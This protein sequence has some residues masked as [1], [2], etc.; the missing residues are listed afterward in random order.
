MHKETYRGFL[1]EE[2]SSLTW[3]DVGSAVSKKARK[4]F[5]ENYG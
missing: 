3:K 5:I 1:I 2:G 4:W